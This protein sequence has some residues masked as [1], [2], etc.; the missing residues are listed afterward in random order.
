MK[1]EIVGINIAILSN[2]GGNEGVGF[3]IPIN[4]ARWIMGQLLA[5]G[6]VHRGALGVILN[7]TFET[8]DARRI[9]LDRPRGAQI[10][11]VGAQSPAA[12]SGISVDDVVLRFNGVEVIDLNHL[13]NIVSMAPI[14]QPAD[15]VIWRGGREWPLKVTVA[16]K[17]R[18]ASQNARPTRSPAANTVLGVELVTLDTAWARSLRLPD[19]SRGA[20]VVNLE[21]DSPLVNYFHQ[22]DVIQ[23]VAGHQ[24]RSAEE[25]VQALSARRATAGLELT[26][27]RIGD[28]GIQLLKVRVP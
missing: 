15:V 9:G 7:P 24:V 19:S 17:D 25:V 28:G 3:S 23:S 20:A 2:G 6:R 8:K 22:H 5:N 21:P 11:S 14:G 26:V 10:L 18:I 27:Q 12:A 16:D 1:G 4:L 13:I